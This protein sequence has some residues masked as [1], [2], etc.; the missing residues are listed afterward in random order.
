MQKPTVGVLC[1]SVLATHMLACARGNDKSRLPALRYQVR[2][3]EA[4]ETQF[5]G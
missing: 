5:C 4:A 3:V 1:S 2:K